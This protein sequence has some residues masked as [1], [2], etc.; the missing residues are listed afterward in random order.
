MDIRISP[1]ST[2][3]GLSRK[4]SNNPS[5]NSNSYVVI[6]SRGKIVN[7]SFES[8]KAEES[9]FKDSHS[10]FGDALLNIYRNFKE[11]FPLLS[12]VESARLISK[13]WKEDKEAKSTKQ[14]DYAA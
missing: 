4:T 9:T 5:F 8:S 12:P 1:V 11:V 3:P 14:L 7:D 6:Y 10:A 13:A 2:Y